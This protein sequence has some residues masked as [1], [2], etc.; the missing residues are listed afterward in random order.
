MAAPVF[1][2]VMEQ[3][4]MY[5]GL[6]PTELNGKLDRFIVEANGAKPALLK[7]SQQ[8]FQGAVPQVQ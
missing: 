5:L 2:E 4:L 3:A 8:K 1:Q 6:I 7:S